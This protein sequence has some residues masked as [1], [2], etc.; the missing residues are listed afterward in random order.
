MSTEDIA[1]QYLN[2][3]VNLNDIKTAETQDDLSSVKS[4]NQS[5]IDAEQEY[6]KFKEKLKVFEGIT[7]L[8]QAKEIAKKFL[9]CK[10]EKNYLRIGNAKCVIIS[11]GDVFRI[12]IDSDKEYICYN[13]IKQS[14]NKHSKK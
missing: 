5:E 1:K 13:I 3:Y 12:C 9:P 6:N 2:S 4:V 11:R 14:D 7:S 10:D 8:S